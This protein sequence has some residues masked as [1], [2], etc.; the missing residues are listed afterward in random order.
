MP[1]CQEPGGSP[2]EQKVSNFLAAHG[3]NRD[4]QA[5]VFNLD[6][7][8]IDVITTL[9]SLALRPHGLTKAGFTIL[10][11]VWITG[12]CETRELAAALGVTKGAIVG[13][14][15][16]LERCGLVTRRRSEDDRRLVT[17][18]LTAAGT[19]MVTRAQKDWRALEE[20]VTADLTT[21]EKRTLSELVRKVSH[22]ARVMRRESRGGNRPQL[23]GPEQFLE[24]SS[25]QPGT[26]A[27]EGVS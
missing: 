1:D 19:E 2:F 17:V 24:S 15:H 18:H 14:V 9:E 3:T 5:V 11:S 16:T 8:A 12:P 13:S 4:S 23:T 7:G 21:N 6:H 10:M 25:G 27:A 26:K 22:R 20:A